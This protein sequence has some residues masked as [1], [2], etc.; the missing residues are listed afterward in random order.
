MLIALLKAIRTLLAYFVIGLFFGGL[1]TPLLFFIEKRNMPFRIWYLID[2]LVCTVAHDT[3]GR[4]ISGWTG[5]HMLSKKRY[6]YQAKVID[7]GAELFGDKP[8]HSM[9][10]YRL[11]RFKGL[12]KA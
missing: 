4:T 7:W 11:E 2:V 5:Q 6:Y 10:M 3:D 1:A 8:N 12:V 9:R